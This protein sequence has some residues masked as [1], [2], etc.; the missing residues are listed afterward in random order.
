MPVTTEMEPVDMDKYLEIAIEVGAE[1]VIL[2]EEE[3]ADGEMKKLL[4]VF[5]QLFDK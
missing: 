3:N 4:K 2:V 5:Y 1:D